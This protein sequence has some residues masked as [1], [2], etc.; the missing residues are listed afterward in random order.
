VGARE[1]GEVA[2]EGTAARSH[3]HLTPRIGYGDELGTQSFGT[4]AL[5]G[6]RGHGLSQR[7]TSRQ[8]SLLW[9]SINF[10]FFFFFAMGQQEESIYGYER[11]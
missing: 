7:A 4:G 8:E 3:S 5:L 10:F 2:D 11:F 6:S 9:S 1:A